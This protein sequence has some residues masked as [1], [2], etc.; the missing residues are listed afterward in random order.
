MKGIKSIVKLA[1]LDQTNY[2]VGCDADNGMRILIITC[3]KVKGKNKFFFE[4]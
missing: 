4:Q 2:A 3:K 1:G